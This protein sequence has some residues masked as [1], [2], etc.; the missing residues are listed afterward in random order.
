[1]ARLETRCK[2][3]RCGKEYTD[4]YECWDPNKII[5]HSEYYC[6]ECNMLLS[7]L[8]YAFKFGEKRSKLNTEDPMETNDYVC[9]CWLYANGYPTYIVANLF[10]PSESVA[11][12]IIFDIRDGESLRAVDIRGILRKEYGVTMKDG[13]HPEEGDK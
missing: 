7:M 12:A 6:P 13:L 11:R 8:L 5:N 10:H 3:D 9:M 2:C 1:M 4:R